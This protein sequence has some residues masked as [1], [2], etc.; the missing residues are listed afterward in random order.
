MVMITPTAYPTCGGTH[1]NDSDH[2][3]LQDLNDGWE[4]KFREFETYVDFGLGWAL[5]IW[6]T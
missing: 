2:Y 1:F 4:M 3:K 6:A 5:V